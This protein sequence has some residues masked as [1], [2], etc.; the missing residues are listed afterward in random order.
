MS[1]RWMGFWL[2]LAVGTAAC[3][4][5]NP[6]AK[7]PQPASGQPPAASEGVQT[8]FVRL[9]YTRASSLGHTGRPVGFR[10]IANYQSS[11]E[12]TEYDGTW[13]DESLTLWEQVSFVIG[14]RNLV[15]VI[16]PVVPPGLPTMI[17]AGREGRLRPV[18]CPP[19]V[20]TMQV[21]YE[22][23]VIRGH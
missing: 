3:T 10:V 16:D 11:N 12:I 18:P 9:T 15:Y 23:E 19:A 17:S 7:A 2:A 4:G 6:A 8:T 14:S 13:E 22:L 1:S 21:C 20:T 5:A